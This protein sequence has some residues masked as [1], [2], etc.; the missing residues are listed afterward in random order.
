LPYRI[1]ENARQYF[2]SKIGILTYLKEGDTAIVN[3]DDDYLCGLEAGAYDLIKVGLGDC[4]YTAGDIVQSARA[5]A[6]RLPWRQKRGFF[7]R[8][9]GEHNVVNC[10]MAIAVGVKYGMSPDEIRR[11]LTFYSLS[12]NRMEIIN[13]K[14]I[15]LI[16]DT[17]NANPEAVKAAVGTLCAMAQSRKIAVLGDMYELGACSEALHE[18]CGR[19]AAERNVDLLLTFGQYGKNYCNGFMQGAGRGRC[20]VFRNQADICDYLK[21]NLIIGDTVL[22]KASHSVKLEEAFLSVKGIL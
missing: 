4:D 15:T 21:K 13:I 11:G 12:A 2:Q 8:Y 19:Y 16:N 18:A 5:F 22:F 1:S 9:T 3:G 20:L 17:Y 10:L 6:L 7:V 14:G